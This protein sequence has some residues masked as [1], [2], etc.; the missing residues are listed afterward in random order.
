MGFLKI[1]FL[2]SWA[3]PEKVWDASE[4]PLRLCPETP[5]LKHNK[6]TGMPSG[7]FTERANIFLI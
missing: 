1:V 6:A 7:G 4:K 5:S 3:I 2:K